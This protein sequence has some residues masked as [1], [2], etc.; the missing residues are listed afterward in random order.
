MARGSSGSEPRSAL[1]RSVPASLLAQVYARTSLLQP[2][3]CDKGT[4]S[5]VQRSTRP[6]GN[7]CR[8]TTRLSRRLHRPA[9]RRG[10]RSRPAP[11]SRSTSM[12]PSTGFHPGA[13]LCGR[14]LA[15]GRP[16][17]AFIT[18]ARP[19]G[20]HC[21]LRDSRRAVG[22]RSAAKTR[23]N[24]F[25]P[26]TAFRRYSRCGHSKRADYRTDSC[27]RPHEPPLMLAPAL[28]CACAR[29]PATGQ[30]RFHS[31]AA[32]SGRSPVGS[33][34]ACQSVS[35]P[36]NTRAARPS[37]CGHTG[38][39]VPRAR[40]GGDQQPPRPHH[41]RTPAVFAVAH[42]HSVKPPSPGVSVWP[43]PSVRPSFPFCFP[44]WTN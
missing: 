2:F 7:G 40:T 32:P 28:R 10:F 9:S 12:T 27:P 1:G 35:A 6:A 24:R 18:P 44:V 23:Q 16:S 42:V 17:C 3:A 39:E 37:G 34:T 33:K 25:A 20:G 36:V 43:A 11:A 15:S 31:G 26:L 38:T 21:V 13:G 14:R 22:L 8:R 29:G 30:R 4:R 5:T 19:D 41:R